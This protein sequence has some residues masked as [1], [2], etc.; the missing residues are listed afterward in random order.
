MI[1]IVPRFDIFILIVTK[2]YTDK[3]HKTHKQHYNM[4]SCPIIA[5]TFRLRTIRGG[6]SSSRQLLSLVEVKAENAANISHENDV[7]TTS[8]SLA[9]FTGRPLHGFCKVKKY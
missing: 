5:Q 3:R 9:T 2:V 1:G 6:Y 4:T 8:K 7:Y